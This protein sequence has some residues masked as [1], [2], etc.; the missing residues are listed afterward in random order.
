MHRYFDAFVY[1]ANWGSRRMMFRI[2]RR[3]LDAKAAA[4]YCDGEALSLAAKKS[5]SC[6][7][8]RPRMR[9]TTSG[10]RGRAGCPR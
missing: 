7:N 5:T 2:P 6:S 1:V 8:S 9:G 4:A 3:F 10:P